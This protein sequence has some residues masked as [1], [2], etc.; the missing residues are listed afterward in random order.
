[1]KERCLRW[2]LGVDKGMPGYL[3]R[4]ELQREKL[5]KA[6]MRAAGR[7]AW[8]F[9]KKLVEG[10]GSVLA[11]KYWENKRRGLGGEIRSGRRRGHSL[12]TEG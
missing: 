7:R 9:E 10:K 12:R 2:V 1:M 8:G 3:V 5:R 4:E 11:R 6:G